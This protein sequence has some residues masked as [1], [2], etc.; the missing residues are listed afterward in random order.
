MIS[1]KRFVLTGFVCCIVAGYVYLA[2]VPSK[3]LKSCGK[4]YNIGICIVATGKYIQFVEPLIKSAE[5]Y[6]LPGHHRTYYVFTDHLDQLFKNK[7]VIGI[8]HQKFGWPYDVLMRFS[9][10]YNNWALLEKNDYLFALDADLLF[11]DTVGDEVLGTLVG[12]QHPG[13]VNRPGTYDRNPQSTAYVRPHEG[14]HYFACA[15]HGAQRDAF[16]KLITTLKENVQQD[17]EHNVIAL[18]HDESHLN[19]YFIDHKP[20]IILSPSYCFPEGAGVAYQGANM[21]YHPRVIALNKNHKA[22]R[23]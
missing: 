18:W 22:V 16:L 9:A 8:S 1:T 5:K 19:R 15:F 17:K 4:S 23:A 13:F 20:D 6:F 10:Y 2:L 7:N 3:P 14:T 21:N 11:V 12:T